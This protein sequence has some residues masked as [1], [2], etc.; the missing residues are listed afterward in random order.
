MRNT[1]TPP[2]KRCCVLHEIM[3]KSFDARFERMLREFAAD[4]PEGGLTDPQNE[5]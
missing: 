1:T 3:P 5:L 2:W 4:R